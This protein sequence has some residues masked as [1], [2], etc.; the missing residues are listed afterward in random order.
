VGKNLDFRQ[1]RHSLFSAYLQ[2]IVGCILVTMSLLPCV[3]AQEISAIPVRLTVPDGTLVKLRL[4][5]SVSS[6]HARVG[7]RLDFVV[8]HDVSVAGF[9]LIPAGTVARGSITE[10]RRK[11]LLGI[12]GNIALKLDSVELANGDQVGLAGSKEV[13]GGSRTKLMLAAMIVTSLV[14][15][16][17]TP[18]FLLIRGHDSTVVKSTEITAQIDGATSILSA[19]LVHSQENSSQL[20]EMMDYLP[21]RVFNGEGR[22]GDMLNLIFV[23]GQEDLQ[24]AFRRAGWVKTDK[25]RLSFVWHLAR[26]G[27]NDAS[28]PMARFYLF[29]RVQDYSYALPDPDAVVSRRHHL[30]I[31]RTDYTAD[32]TP[33]WVGAATHDVAIEIAKR[34]RLINH[35]IDPAVD[36]ERDFIGGNL[37]ETSSVRQAYL[38]GVDP[39]F[40][41]QTASGETYYSD[42][43]ILL[44]D[45]SRDIFTQS[46][47]SGQSSVAEAGGENDV[48]LLSSVSVK[49]SSPGI[50]PIGVPSRES[51]RA[52]LPQRIEN[53][54]RTSM[55]QRLLKTGGD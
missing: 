16:P 31:W 54:P 12:G 49:L 4:A 8:V 36:A 28:L 52:A 7:D 15:L 40:Q 30:R 46:G 13:K 27:T 3:S 37:A 14:F 2:R 48:A 22:E 23:A 5:Q 1:R 44:L 47:M 29:G 9:T 19:G 51:A 17:A 21:P 35:R 20:G 25:W 41:A 55:Q 10:V 33:I 6:A 32:G 42:S 45:L 50:E 53:W 39:V 11:R 38:Y 24:K 18:V 43:R 26:Y 34:G